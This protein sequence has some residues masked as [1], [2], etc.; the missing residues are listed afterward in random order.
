[1]F[2]WR[3]SCEEKEKNKNKVTQA[4]ESYSSVVLINSKAP[5]KTLAGIEKPHVCACMCV[6]VVALFSHQAL[7]QNNV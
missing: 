5:G 1:M 6:C 3:N 4:S 7:F 2:L